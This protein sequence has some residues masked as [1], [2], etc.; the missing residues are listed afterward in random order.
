MSSTGQNFVN[1]V[2]NTIYVFINEELKMGLG[3]SC[4]QT[5]HAVAQMCAKMPVA[6]EQT[7][8]EYAKNPSRVVVLVARTEAQLH[9]IL[10]YCEQT[11]HIHAEPYIDEGYG[12]HMTALATQPIPKAMGDNAF[13]QMLRYGYNADVKRHKT[14][15]D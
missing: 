10:A 7:L 9:S 1:G 3:E 2:D 12:C 14:W 8:D 11:L 5:A 15:L 13:Q 6:Y 4:A